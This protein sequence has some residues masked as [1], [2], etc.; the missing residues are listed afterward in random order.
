MYSPSVSVHKNVLTANISAS[1]I[2]SG[3]LHFQHEIHQERVLE[4][5][6][7]VQI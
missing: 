6:S 5:L 7:N 4:M 3:Y 1:G 2:H